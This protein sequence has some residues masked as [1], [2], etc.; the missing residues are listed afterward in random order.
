MK[1]GDTFFSFQTGSPGNFPGKRKSPSDYR[2]DQRRRKPPGK[3]MPTPGN[4]GVSSVAPGDT[5][6]VPSSP[7]CQT[8]PANPDPG[9]T[10]TCL[11]TTHINPPWGGRAWTRATRVWTRATWVWTR[12]TR[13]WTRATRAWTRATWAW[14]RAT[15]AWTGATR[16]WTLIER[17]IWS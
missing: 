11:L 3:G 17:S 5:T 15:R 10:T 8:A 1:L 12:A 16:A 7:I 14:T 4:Y 13:V 6:P 9:P 2:R